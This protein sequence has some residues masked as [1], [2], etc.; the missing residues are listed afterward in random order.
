MKIHPIYN[1][2]FWSDQKRT[3]L[4]YNEWIKESWN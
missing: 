1:C 2:M 3:F 4:P